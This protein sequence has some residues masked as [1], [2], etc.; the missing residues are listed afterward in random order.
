MKKHLKYTLTSLSILAI[1]GLLVG[2]NGAATTAEA[3]DIPVVADA[4]SD[5]VVAEAVIEPARS[6]E[7]SFEM[8]GKV[9]E[10]LVA[11]GDA[12][13]EG[14][15]IARLQTEDLDR[16]LTQADLNLRQAQLRLEQLEQP[17]E[18]RDVASAEAA[19]ASAQAAYNE[20]LQQLTL[21]EHSQ[22]TGE[23]V[24]AARYARDEAYRVY[25]D[26]VAKRDSGER[27]IGDSIV[28][29]AHDAYLDADGQY[30]RAVE[31]AEFEL[32]SARN[33]VNE[34]H[35]AVEQAGRDLEA[36]LEEADALDLQAAQLEIEAA[37]L[38]LEEAESALDDAIL[39]AP[40]DGTV[41]TLTVD[42]GDTVGAGQSALVLATLDEL[43]AVTKDLTELDVVR[44]KAG[45]DVTVSVDAMPDEEFAGVVS[46][47]AL[48]PGD[49]RGDVV[50]AITVEL[51]DVD[52]PLYW[53]MTALVEIQAE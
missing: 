33:A 30:N 44:V 15:V 24:R 14:D 23:E 13:E 26:L 8:G 7:L 53:G 34:A 21:T 39:T 3:T 4:S 10:V 38:A 41:A 17:P 6:E 11:E 5:T 20:A 40:F 28:A 50:Y 18:E 31:R 52:A 35:R 1:A 36:V 25:Q 32:L 16:A 19:V 9:V 48:Q 37:A 29:R 22:A 12:V 49:Y 51:A 45:Q 2:C 43:Q 47:I 46:E 27:S 42:V